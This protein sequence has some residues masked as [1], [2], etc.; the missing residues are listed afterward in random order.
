MLNDLDYPYFRYKT[1]SYLHKTQYVCLVF[2]VVQL[3]RIPSTFRKGSSLFTRSLST[4]SY[5]GWNCWGSILM[6]TKS[7]LIL[8]C[9]IFSL[10]H[11]FVNIIW[12]GMAM[13]RVFSGTR[14]V[15]PLMGRG[16][17]LI[18]EFGTGMRF[19][20]K[21]R[22]G[23]VRVWVLPHPAPILFTY[24]INFKIKL[25]LNFKINLI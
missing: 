8:M 19:F 3:D 16:L 11:F 2:L 1:L 15:P 9:Y 25:N 6:N 10:M 23:S 13:G 18:N 4:S 20:F 24:K 7:N 22:A 14:P 21:P 5:R 12:V 17:N